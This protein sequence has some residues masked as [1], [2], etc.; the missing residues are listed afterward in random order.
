[1][2]ENKSGVVLAVSAYGTL[3]TENIHKCSFS[4]FSSFL[5]LF[6]ILEFIVEVF[7]F[8]FCG[9]ILNLPPG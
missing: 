6:V 5:L 3:G 2:M 4:C 8:A 7:T 1:M 9:T